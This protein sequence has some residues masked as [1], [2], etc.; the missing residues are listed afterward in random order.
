MPA[1]LRVG[2]RVRGAGRRRVALPA[3]RDKRLDLPDYYL[4]M[5]QPAPV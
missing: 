5:A 1:A 2:G 4:V 3:W